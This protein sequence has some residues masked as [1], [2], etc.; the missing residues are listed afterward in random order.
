MFWGIVA[1]RRGAG[2]IVGLL[3]MLLL[4]DLAA[5]I[6]GI[7]RGCAAGRSLPRPASPARPPN[8]AFAGYLTEQG[9]EGNRGFDVW[10]RFESFGEVQQSADWVFFRLTYG[11]P[12]PCAGWRQVAGWVPRTALLLTALWLGRERA[13]SAEAWTALWAAASVWE[14][15]GGQLLLTPWRRA[16]R[17]WCLAVALKDASR[18]EVRDRLRRPLPER[19]FACQGALER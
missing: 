18:E 6:R 7:R 11:P 3:G 9:V 13:G 2:E 16:E 12:K 19:S 1:A 14:P 8:A 15:L 17:S 5:L 4:P 10:S